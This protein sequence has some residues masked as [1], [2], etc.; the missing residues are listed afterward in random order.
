MIAPAVL[1]PRRRV[2]LLII[3][4]LVIKILVVSTLIDVWVRCWHSAP[5]SLSV[6]CW[7]EIRS[8]VTL[9]HVAL[10]HVAL[11]YVALIRV[12][13]IHVTLIHVTLIHTRI[14]TRIHKTWSV[15]VLIVQIRTWLLRKR[16]PHSIHIKRVRIVTVLH[17]IRILVTLTLWRQ[18][19]PCRRALGLRKFCFRWL[20]SG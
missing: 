20:W 18:L 9:A 19:S 6:E 10:V 3:R 13:L 1:I 14:H 2:I 5:T 16:R 4:I 7:S 12:S 11:V 17:T 15:H 8:D